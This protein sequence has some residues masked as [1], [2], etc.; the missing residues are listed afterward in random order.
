M[1]CK[2]MRNCDISGIGAP[3]QTDDRITS[4]ESLQTFYNESGIK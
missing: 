2:A 4:R 1:V 3:G